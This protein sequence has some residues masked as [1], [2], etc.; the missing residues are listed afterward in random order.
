MDSSKPAQG[1]PQQL[2]QGRLAALRWG[3]RDAPVWVCLHGWLDN[4]ATFSRLAPLLCEQLDVQLVA[5]E[6]SGHGHSRWREAGRY[7]LWDYV[8]DVVAALDDLG[9][10][11]AVILGHSLGAIVATLLA[12]T[13]PERVERLLLIDGLVS[14]TTPSDHVVTQ[15]REALLTKRRDASSRRP[16]RSF[17]QAVDARVLGAVTPVDADT[18]APVV[19]RNLREEAAGLVLRSDVALHRPSPLRFT[20]EQNLAM[21]RALRCPVSVLAARHGILGEPAREAASVVPSLNWIALEGG[22]HL[23]LEKAQVAAVA[24]AIIGEV[25]E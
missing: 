10:E 12:A 21:L 20:H 16:Y 23:H 15:L 1:A 8:E 19:A 4:A 3:R 24:A 11:R 18:I 6:L 2:V 9:L 25:S 17:E 14:Q 22:H 7:L 13:L 5:V